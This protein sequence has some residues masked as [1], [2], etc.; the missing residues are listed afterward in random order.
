MHAKTKFSRCRSLIFAKMNFPPIDFIVFLILLVVGAIIVYK[1]L[2]TVLKVAL[3]I[4][5]IVI[6]YILLKIF[7]F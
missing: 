7:V 4:A 1:V 2:K 6:A 5:A 3:W